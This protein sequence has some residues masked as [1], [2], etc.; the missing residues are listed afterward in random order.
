MDSL[1]ALDYAANGYSLLYE[2]G[3]FKQKIIDGEQVEL[4]DEWLASGGA[5][6]VPHPERSVS[7][8][9]GGKLKEEWDGSSLKITN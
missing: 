5:W 7:I 2:T 4:P 8:R 3:L 9:L 1:S 6:L